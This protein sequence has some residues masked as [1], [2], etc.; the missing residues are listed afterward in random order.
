MQKKKENPKQ[1]KR[2]K[3]EIQGLKE[4]KENKARDPLPKTIFCIK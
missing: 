4:E 3:K 1:K 2:W